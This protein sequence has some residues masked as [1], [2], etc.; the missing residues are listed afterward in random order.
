MMIRERQRQQR[1]ADNFF[2]QAQRSLEM[3]YEQA[4]QTI[5]AT[6]A[7]FKSSRGLMFA[8]TGK[9]V[10]IHTGSRVNVLILLACVHTGK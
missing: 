5:T 7:Y 3:W 8:D 4:Q 2:A 10:Y 1:T 9:Y 6:Y